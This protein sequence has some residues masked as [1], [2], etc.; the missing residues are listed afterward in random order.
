LPTKIK[1]KVASHKPL[2]KL[3]LAKAQKV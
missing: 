2:P 3:D 1:T